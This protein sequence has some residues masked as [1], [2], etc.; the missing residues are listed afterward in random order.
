[1]LPDAEFIN[2]IPQVRIHFISNLPSSCRF[3]LLILSFICPFRPAP[4]SM[5]NWKFGRQLAV[6]LKPS[7]CSNSN[8]YSSTMPTPRKHPMTISQRTFSSHGYRHATALRKQWRWIWMTW[9]TYQC[10][11]QIHRSYAICR[12][13]RQRQRTQQSQRHKATKPIPSVRWPIRRKQAAPVAKAVPTF[14]CGNFWKSCWHRHRTT[15]TPFAGWTVPRAYSKLK[16][17]YAWPVSGASVRIGR[18]WTMTNCPDRYGNTTKK[19]LW[20]KRNDRSVWFINSVRHTRYNWVCLLHFEINNIF[21]TISV[22]YFHRFWVVCSLNKVLEV[23][24]LHK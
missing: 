3:S 7:S 23:Q 8:K 11:H 16:I 2:R 6:M 13:H 19:V 18:P 4:Q 5:L 24:L 10:S 20:K 1:M 12:R 21:F 15:G 9:T 22:M 14:I 17:R